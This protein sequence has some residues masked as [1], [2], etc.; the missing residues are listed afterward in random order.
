MDSQATFGVWLKGRRKA[1]DLTQAELAQQ[2]GCAEVTLRKMEANARRPSKLIAVRLAELLQ[3]APDERA[4]FVRFA[5]GERSGLPP[6]GAPESVASHR[7]RP[8]QPPSNLPAQLTPLIGRDRELTAIQRSILH[9]GSRLLTLVGPPGVGKTRLALAA[10]RELVAHF[11]DGV[12]FVP[13]A[14]LRD[15]ALVPAVI[16]QT[17]G[18]QENGLSATNRLKQYLDDKHLL[19]V[20]DNVEHLLAAAPGVVEWLA[21]CAWLHVLVTSRAALRVRAERQFPVSPLALPDL[22]YLPETEAL[23]HYGAVALLVERAQAVDPTFALT[24]E[25]AAAVATLCVRLDGLPLAIELI[26]AR[27]KLLPPSALLAQLEGKHGVHLLLES[28]GPQDSLPQH[29]TLGYAID[30]SYVLLTPAEQRLFVRLS[31]FAGGFTLATAEA[32]G[33]ADGFPAFDLFTGVASLLDKNLIY[34]QAG[35]DGEPRFL[36]L[37]TIHEYARER[38]AVA[39]EIDRLQQR[40]AELFLRLAEEAAP[41]LQ[42]AGQQRWLECLTAEHDNLRAALAWAVASQATEIAARLGAALWHFWYIRG[43]YEEGWLW[44]QRL[45]A[46]ADQPA[47]RAP[48][49][50]GLGMLARRHSDYMAAIRYFEESCVLFRALGDQRG[51]ASALRGLGFIHHVQHDLARARQRLEEALGLFRQLDDS[52][53]AAVALANLGYIARGQNDMVQAETYFQASLALRRRTGNQHGV[54]NVL[55]ALAYSAIAAGEY[56]QA[57]RYAQESLELSQAL[58]N[59]NGIGTALNILGVITFAEGDYPTA[60][61]RHMKALKLG[62]ET[63][64]RSLQPS[65]TARLGASALKLNDYEGAYTFLTEALTF[66]QTS[67]MKRELARTLGYIAGLALAQGQPQKALQLAGA[68]A[69]LRLVL[70]FCE[71]PYEQAEFD[72]TEAAARRLLDEETAATAWAAGQAMSVEQAVHCALTLKPES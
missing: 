17:L 24:A 70:D 40:H 67:D 60:H 8:S 35:S 68:A 61:E 27:V 59:Q 34:Q 32:V 11:A 20:L 52:E 16:C 19:L 25:N 30:W 39:G 18:Q 26:A 15:P 4:A 28:D 51:I 21:A 3:I 42:G 43:H 58:G 22:T 9:E 66:F 36:M 1:F 33:C 62:Q 57:R 69:Q 49:L 6:A 47:Q 50:Y 46:L 56:A 37:E 7:W 5:R 23:A 53:G 14:T 48:L 71:L 72:Q 10:A 31:V 54:A 13:L 65:A 45:L 55:G 38:L 41:H 29:Q 2:V 64:D 44:L 12:F 63:G